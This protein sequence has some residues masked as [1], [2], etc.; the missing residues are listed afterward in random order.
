MTTITCFHAS[1]AQKSYGSEK[2][3]LCPPPVIT[4]TGAESSISKDR[5]PICMSVMCET[6]SEPLEQ[7]SNFDE[8]NVGCFKFLHVSGTAKAKQFT[9]KLKI[10]NKNNIPFATFDSVPISIISKP[11]KKTSKTRNVSSCILSGS[12][13]SLF[14][15]I[16]SQT[17]RTKCMG[18]SSGMLC[19][20]S[21]DWTAFTITQLNPKFRRKDGAILTNGLAAASSANTPITYGSQIVLTDSKSGFM[22]DPLFV[23]K[24]DKGRI[25][26]DASGPVSQM[27][28][29][30][31]QKPDDTGS[32][33]LMYLSASGPSDVQESNENPFLIYKRAKLVAQQPGTRSSNIDG[34]VCEE[35]E[36]FLCWTIVGICKF[37][38]TYFETLGPATRP[39]TPFPSL[40]SAP[41]YK[42]H[43]NTLELTVRHFHAHD[44]PLEVWLGNHG[45]LDVRIIWPSV[46]SVV[47]KGHETVFVAHLPRL[48]EVFSAVTSTEKKSKVAITL[49]LLFVRNDG[50]VYDV[51]RSLVYE[52][53]PGR[54][55]TIRIV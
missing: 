45:P 21:W 55:R 24:V 5:A 12:T 14:N 43:T 11:S 36:D 47:M 40:S 19:G 16:N 51:G 10:L 27:Q 48:D 20:K 29:V 1:V 17:A 15:R 3:F 6:G 42:P 22:S 35:I 54:P 41:I 49:P 8:N 32:G 37:E 25:E 38:Y 30:A 4:I 13:V 33:V 23:R 28:K 53:T 2:R 31:L 44:Q 50:I 26:T 7:K 9:L 52:E 39:I 34:A 18:V 46:G